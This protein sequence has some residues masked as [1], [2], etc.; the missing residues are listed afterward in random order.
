MPEPFDE[1]DRNEGT[2]YGEE[3]FQVELDVS[4]SQELLDGPPTHPPA[5]EK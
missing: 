5:A 2:V 3:E 1:H 4:A